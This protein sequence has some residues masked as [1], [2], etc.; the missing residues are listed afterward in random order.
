M[1]TDCVGRCPV[2]VKLCRNAMWGSIVGEGFSR[3]GSGYVGRVSTCRDQ[4]M[5]GGCLPVGIRLC[6]EGVSL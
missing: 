6:W 3:W 4:A 1:R 5:L 2:G